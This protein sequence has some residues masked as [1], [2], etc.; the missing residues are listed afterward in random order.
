MKPVLHLTS[1]KIIKESFD[2]LGSSKDIYSRIEYFYKRNILVDRIY[3]NID[4]KNLQ[5]KLKYINKNN[6]S[7]ILIEQS[8]GLILQ[9][10]LYIKF[11]K[12]IYRS[13]NAEFYH[14]LHIFTYNL[15]HFFNGILLNNK[16]KSPKNF[17]LILYRTFIVYLLNIFRFLARDLLTSILSKKIFSNCE[18]E[19]KNYWDYFAKSKTFNAT[20]FLSG[21]YLNK[22]NSEEDLIKI[23]KNIIIISGSMYPNPI[24]YEQ[25]ASV[26]K[27]KSLEQKDIFKKFKF[28]VTGKVSNGILNF[29]VKQKI[30]ELNNFFIY[31]D[32]NMY[33]DKELRNFET[34]QNTG[35]MKHFKILGN[36]DY[37]TYY[38]LLKKSKAMLFLTKAGFGFKNKSLEAYATKNSLIMPKGLAERFP[39]ELKRIVYSYDKIYDLLDILIDID[40][41]TNFVSDDLN[42]LIRKSSFKSY[43]KVFLNNEII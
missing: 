17:V 43:D 28:L 16:K 39:S 26:V 27:L 37:L 18:W 20:P 6:Y 30:N 1:S 4:F 21:K 15:K 2:L 32:K 38:D 36:E 40:K 23:K 9:I 5:N 41:K 22:M 11:G 12:I 24:S 10:Y 29:L 14:R 25:I 19:K 42:G 34:N 3:I 13:H 8:P 31:N 7:E 33:K 35:L